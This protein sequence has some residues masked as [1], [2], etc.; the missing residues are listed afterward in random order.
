MKLS[1]E[2][3][4]ILRNY[5]T[6]NGNL[7]IKPGNKLNTITASKAV[8]SSVT[9]KETFPND[10]GVYDL[11]EFL[12]VLSLFNDPEID[13]NDK[14]AVI[15]DGQQAFRFYSADASVL[16]AP[17]KELKLPPADVE[18][19]LTADQI[20]MFSKSAG[21]LRAQD[22]V[23]TGSNGVL[24]ASVCDKKNSTGNTYDVELGSTDATF[25]VYI[26][27]E[28]WKLIPGQYKAEISSKKIAK[29]TS[30]DLQYV[31]ALEGDSTFE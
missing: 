20:N 8:Y 28:N 29:F 24:T 12:G 30:G 16:T 14:Y 15:K 13:F 11:S 22:L 19:D 6:I 17:T 3:V 27:F 5:A 4:A 25:K 23:F 7:L 21:V 31:M 2:T 1:K 18:F 10:F 9:V 26:R